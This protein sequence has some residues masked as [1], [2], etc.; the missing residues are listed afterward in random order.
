M[1]RKWGVNSESNF[2]YRIWRFLSLRILSDS[3]YINSSYLSWIGRCRVLLH[4]LPMTSVSLRMFTIESCLSTT[5]LSNSSK[6]VEWL[7]CILSLVT[8]TKLQQYLSL[9]NPWEVYCICE[10]HK[11]IAPLALFLGGLIWFLLEWYLYSYE[12]ERL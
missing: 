5:F 9:L 12:L 11:L 2:L 1:K 3:H 8:Y 7:Y 6:Q 10:Q 4:I